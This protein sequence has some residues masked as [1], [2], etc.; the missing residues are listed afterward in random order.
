MKKK[1]LYYKTVIRYIGM[2][3][4]E[5][6]IVV[7]IDDNKIIKM[8]GI[9]TGDYLAADIKDDVIMLDYYTREDDMEEYQKE[10]SI[11]LDINSIELPLN[12]SAESDFIT[13]EI[14]TE[15]MILKSDEKVKCERILSEFK[16]NVFKKGR[17]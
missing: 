12:V 15:H 17:N 9:F 16:N 11:E 13:I 3:K 14:S 8:E 1:T 6:F 7:E 2:M 10:F 4:N 5:G